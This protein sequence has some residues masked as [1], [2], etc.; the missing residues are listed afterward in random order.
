[1]KNLYIF[2][3]L[4]LFSG[5]SFAQL[6]TGGPDAYGYTWTDSNEPNGPTYAWFDITTIGT[7]VTG[8]SDDNIVGPFSFIDGFQFYWYFPTQV[9]IGSNGYLSFNGSNIASPFPTIPATAAP[10]NF[11]A[12]FLSDLNFF[13]T[14][15]PASCYYYTAGDTIC[16]SYHNVPFWA[17]AN[18]PYVGSN[19]FQVILNR[20][21]KSITYNYQSMTG[22]TNGND[23]TIGIENITGQL[24]LQHSKN[25]YPANNYTIRFKYPDTVTYQAVDGGVNWNLSNGNG[26]VF[27]NTGSSNVLSTNIRNFG[28]QP[29]SG[30]NINSAVTRAGTPPLNNTAALPQLAAGADSTVSLTNAFVPTTAGIYQMSTTISGITGDLVPANNSLNSKIIAVDTTQASVFLDYSDGAP[31]GAGLSWSGGSG[32]IGYYITPSFYP[33]RIDA[34]RIYITADA[35]SQGCHLKIFDDNGPNGG[36]GTLLDSTF[37]APGAFGLNTYSPVTLSTANLDITDGG[38]Y[39]LWE[40]PGGSSITL[41]RDLTAPISNRAFEVL[42]GSWAGY[43]SR[44]TEDFLFGVEARQVLVEDIASTALLSPT[45]NAILTTPTAPTLRVKNTGQ[46]L[47]RQ[48]ILKYQF[49]A[50]P[51]V[52]ESLFPNILGPGDSLTYTFNNLI[53]APTTTTDQLCV[54]VEMQD[55]F[56]PSNDTICIPI[57][58]EV[59]NTSVA[60]QKLSQIT[61]YPNPTTDQVWINLGTLQE[62]VSL[63]ITDM[64]GRTLIE[65]TLDP[66]VESKV[67]VNTSTLSEGIYF[68]TFG[69]AGYQQSIRLLKLR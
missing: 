8:L 3:F 67:Q 19:T 1:M 66:R 38:F 58:Y 39:I 26:A 40:M 64:T 47:N 37:A 5:T 20:S 22:L 57:T 23:I 18:P 48:I 27:V 7:P 29:L 34:Y 62:V 13:G 30:I 53:S 59:T 51:I 16:V 52:S 63:K 24:G 56:D 65:E 42:G 25:T 10:N 68:C 61:L 4:M 12:P 2:L 15:N 35:T 60:D 43:R 69:L 21:D 33:C 9:W 11:I 50:Q 55:D 28:N 6:A 44:A 54:W 32:G 41:A 14:G 49:G 36:P 17:N 46:L 31:D 45:A